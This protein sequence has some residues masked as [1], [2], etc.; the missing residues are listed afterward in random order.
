VEA[1]AKVSGASKGGYQP[2]NTVQH[3]LVLLNLVHKYFG[4]MGGQRAVDV[5][6]DA[7]A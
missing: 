4:L 6:S 2:S 3:P 5:V 1:Q 7:G